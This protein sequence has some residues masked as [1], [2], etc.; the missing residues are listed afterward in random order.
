M[1]FDHHRAKPK[2]PHIAHGLTEANRRQ[3]LAQ[4]LCD[5]GQIREES[6][7]V[8]IRVEEPDQVKIEPRIEKATLRGIRRGSAMSCAGGDEARGC[9]TE[10]DAQASRSPRT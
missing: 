2:P 4:L 3:G 10:N 6:V 1:P 8:C 7:G 9:R 5:L